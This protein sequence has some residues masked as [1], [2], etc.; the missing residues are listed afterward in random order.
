MQ[1]PFYF[2]TSKSAVQTAEVL[3]GLLDLDLP[4]DSPRLFTSLIPPNER[5]MDALR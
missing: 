3:R 2:A 4:P 1:S 5:K